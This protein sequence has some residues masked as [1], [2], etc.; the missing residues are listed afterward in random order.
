MDSDFV[1]IIFVI[2]AIVLTVLFFKYFL[3][4]IGVLAAVIAIISVI[5]HMKKKNGRKQMVLED[6]SKGDIEDFI[7]NSTTRIQNLRRYYYKLKEEDMRLSL[8]KTTDSMKK[9]LSI[10]K[11]DPRDY[12]AIRRFLNIT[13]ESS[14]KILYQSSQLYSIE[15]P[16]DKTQKGLSDAKEGLKLL[17]EAMDKQINKSYDNNAMDLDIE[18]KVLKKILSAKGLIN[19]SD[20]ENEDG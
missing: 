5:R 15:N 7:K 11:E 10:L 17:S 14:D 1:E 18:V 13:L 4:I 2:G 20:K 3:V 8:D 9:I 6:V 12:K 19:E 16:D